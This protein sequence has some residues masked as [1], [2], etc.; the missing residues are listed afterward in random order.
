[1]GGGGAGLAGLLGGSA[2]LHW[3]LA[4]CFVRPGLGWAGL[5]GASGGC[6]LTGTEVG[7]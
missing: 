5:L 4:G 2:G 7:V 6:G 1:M 3:G